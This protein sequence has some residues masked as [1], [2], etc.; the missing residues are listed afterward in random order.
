MA[1]AVLEPAQDTV[2]DALFDLGGEQAPKVTVD[3]RAR[4]IAAIEQERQIDE[5]EFGDA[6]GEV[7][8]R[9]IA[10][11]KH[12]ILNEPRISSAR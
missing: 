2:V 9:L 4:G 6:V 10:E 8:R 3:R 7:A 12:A 5:A 1:E 11:R